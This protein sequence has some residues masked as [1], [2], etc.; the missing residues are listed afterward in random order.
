MTVNRICFNVE[1]M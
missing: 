1:G